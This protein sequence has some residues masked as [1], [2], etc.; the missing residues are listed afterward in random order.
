MVVEVSKLPDRDN[1]INEVHLVTGILKND[2]N[3]RE[4]ECCEKMN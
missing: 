4:R 2:V 1:N 3:K